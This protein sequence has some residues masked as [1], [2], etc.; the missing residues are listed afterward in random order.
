[1]RLPIDFVLV[2]RV[3][4]SNSQNQCDIV[5][6]SCV[7]HH[8]TPISFAGILNP[9]D[10][11]HHMRADMASPYREGVVLDKPVKEGKGSFVNVGLLKE[12]RIDKHLK[13]GIRV[14]VKLDYPENIGG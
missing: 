6:D 3:T 11:P 13:P 5:S 10:S 7:S 1:M 12:I 14:T 9:L 8:S 2:W 4:D